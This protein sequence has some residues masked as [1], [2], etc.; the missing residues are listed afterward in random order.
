[1]KPGEKSSR[2]NF[3]KLMKESAM[4]IFG[5]EGAFFKVIES[6]ASS[7]VAEGTKYEKVKR[8]T[9]ATNSIALLPTREPLFSAS[10]I[11]KPA[12]LRPG[13]SKLSPEFAS[14]GEIGTCIGAGDVELIPTR[15]ERIGAFPATMPIPWALALS[16]SSR[17]RV[18]MNVW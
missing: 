14:G 3:T 9:T 15:L 4:S 5:N 16:T 18:L 11:N 12:I 17:R 2:T 13:K 8:H 6:P 10:S 1:M 7:K